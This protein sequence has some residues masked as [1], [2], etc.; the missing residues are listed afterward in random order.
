[1]IKNYTKF[2]LEEIA[3]AKTDARNVF[4]ELIF[5]GVYITSWT[6]KEVVDAYARLYYNSVKEAGEAFR[7][8]INRLIKTRNIE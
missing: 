8:E 1:M 7:N 3:M 4:E 5:S 2:E 6:Y